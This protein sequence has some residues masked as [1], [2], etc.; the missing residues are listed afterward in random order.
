M[1]SLCYSFPRGY[2]PIP[3]EK[4]GFSRE[5]EIFQILSE[6]RPS[7]RQDLRVQASAVCYIGAELLREGVCEA[8]F[9]TLPDQP[10]TTSAVL[11]LSVVPL[12]GDRPVWTDGRASKFAASALAEMLGEENPGSIV[13]VRNLPVG[14][15][16]MMVRERSHRVFSTP[17]EV[18]NFVELQVFIPAPDVGGM[19]VVS[20]STRSTDYC[21]ELADIGVLFLNSL[22][23]E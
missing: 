21:T 7:R 6:A 16:A 12:K 11:T 22:V 15:V 18:S 4:N 20:M 13:E 9:L 19:V 5:G 1:T 10:S 17:D 8:G 14:P 2:V 3:L 23:F